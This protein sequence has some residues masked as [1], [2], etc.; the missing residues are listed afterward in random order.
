MLD[1]KLIR[2]KLDF[3]EKSLSLRSQKIDLKPVLELDDERKVLIA[4]IETLRNVR[5]KESQKIGELKRK[6]EE[7]SAGMLEK[8]NEM[9]N[10][11][12]D[13][14]KELS[15]I[16]KKIE[17]SLLFIPNM[18]DESV[19]A[20]SSSADNKI[21]RVAG[22]PLQFSFKPKS[23]WELGESLGILDFSISAKISGS[24]FA[25]F[26]N[27]GAVLERAIISFF[28]D[29]HKEKGYQ[30]ILTPYLVNSASMRGTGQLP[31]FAEEAFKCADDDLYLIPTAEVPVTNIY[32]DDCLDEKILPQKF[33]SYSACFRR[34][35]GAY[36]KDTKGLIRNHQFDKVEL[37]KF[38]RPE[39]SMNE[40]EL[41]TKD[42]ESVL[43]KLELPYR[44]SLLCGGDLGFSSSKTYDLEVWLPFENAYRE[45]SS[46]SNFKDFQARRMNIKMKYTD[47]R[48][49]FLHTLNG[50]G[51]A[52]GRTFL[53]I[54][55]NFQQ[56]DGS[57]IIPNALRKYTNFDIIVKK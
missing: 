45:I 17:E 48:R 5:N 21:V 49:E 2:S 41:L 28:L 15:V 13:K 9:R 25:V 3:V 10:T 32:R 53:A 20:G 30:E 47:G 52:V 18:P 6:G 40:L 27:E 4:E 33:V 29:S 38:V 42:A 8:I 34:E 14:E 43:E 31:K 46:C 1:I 11:I 57:V 39:D 56:E 55:E 22:N 36:G 24:R 44:V 12:Q 19:P 16:E 50:S 37:V 23:H 7:A 54:L 35:A 26:K 51:V